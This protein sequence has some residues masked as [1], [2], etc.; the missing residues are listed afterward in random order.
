MKMNL[1]MV[2]LLIPCMNML[3]AQTEASVVGARA[4]GMGHNSLVNKDLWS[5]SNNQASAAYLMQITAGV[6]AENRYMLQE[7][8]RIVLGVFIPV[9]KGGLFLDIDHFGGD[10]YAEMKIGAGY[11]RQMGKH[12]SFGLQ[13]DY[14]RMTIGEAYGSSQ[15]LTFEAGIM[16]EITEILSMGIH[17][18]NPIHTSWMGAAEPIPVTIRAGI[19][20]RPEPSLN[21]CAEILKSTAS[22]AV[23]SV[24]CEYRL[25]ERFFVRAGIGSGPARYTFGAGMKIRSLMINIASSVN[26]Y[27][28]YSPQISFI[29]QFGK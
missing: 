17:I 9:T 10:I 26:A 14:L 15:A 6:F 29:Y 13:L 2:C 21:I 7:M 18:F 25:R 3:N 4:I 22:K 28:G 23:I 5:I 27:L 24:G 1:F 11:A 8:N 12:F 19:G 20:V 16:A